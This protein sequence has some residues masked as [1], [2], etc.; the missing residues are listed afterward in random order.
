[1][2]KKPIKYVYFRLKLQYKLGSKGKWQE[3]PT[4]EIDKI[5]KR[6]VRNLK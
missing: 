3:D 4:G 6:A 1:M 5:Y 2:K